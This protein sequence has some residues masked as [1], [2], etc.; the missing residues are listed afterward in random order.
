MICLHS[1]IF[2][3]KQSKKSTFY[4]YRK[5]LRFIRRAYVSQK[6]DP[7]CRKP[8]ILIPASRQVGILLLSLGFPRVTGMHTDH[9]LKFP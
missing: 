4:V 1:D 7:K 6:L 2:Y 5:T 9:R 3:L 8:C